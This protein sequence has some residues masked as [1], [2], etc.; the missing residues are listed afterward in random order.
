MRIADILNSKRPVYSFEFFPP[1]TDKGVEEVMETAA[2]LKSLSPDFISVT[3]GAGGT[4]R[5][6]TAELTSRF[7]RDAGLEPMAHL[8][9]VDSTREDIGSVLD[10][11]KRNGLENILALRGDPPSGQKQ[12]KPTPGGFAFS[13]ELVEYIAKGPWHFS[14]GVAGYPEGHPECLNKT[15]D[16]ENLKRKLDA[17]ASFVITQLFFD[18]AEFFRFR[19]E[20]AR[21][22][23][24][25]PIIAG[26]MPILNVGQIKRFVSMCGSKIPHPLLVSLES[27]EADP[28]EVENLGI[29]HAIRQCEELVREGVAGIHFYT[30]NRSK[31]TLRILSHLRGVPVPEVL[32]P[33][34]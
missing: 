6:R 15:R 14:I 26:I 21:L 7:K 29:G 28:S 24:T 33:S 23:V 32:S 11:H 31:A 13:S 9:C 10:E 5:G 30:L 20:C 16:I 3:Y 8:T 2:Q 1:K 19:E 18:N 4:T 22:G 12:F 25:A 17:G 34:R 27:A